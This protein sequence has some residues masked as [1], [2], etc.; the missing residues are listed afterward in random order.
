MWFNTLLAS[1]GRQRAHAGRQAPVA[2]PARGQGA[3]DHAAPR[4]VARRRPVAVGAAGGP[5]PPGHG[6]GHGGLRAQ[7]PVRLPVDEDRTSPKLFKNFK[8]APYPEVERRHSRP[9]HHRRHQPGREQLLASTPTWPSR[10]RCASAT[11]TTR[12]SAPSRAACRRRSPTSTTT[13]RSSADYPFRQDIQTS[14][15]DRRGA[16]ADARVPEH[17]DRHLAR[18]VAARGHRPAEHGAEDVEPDRRTPSTRRDWCRDR[19]ERPERH[20]RRHHRRGGTAAPRPSAKAKPTVRGRPGR[21][22]AR[23]DAVRAGRDH[24]ARRHRL[25]DRLRRSTCRCSATT[26]ASRRPGQV[27]RASPT[28][29]PCCRSPYW[30]HALV[31]H[32]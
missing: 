30:W 8:W 1:A 14:L 18:R 31:G 19:T 16:A 25:P 7:L 21:A 28:T 32:A 2:R 23:L 17:L 5:E 9:R 10:R 11:G 6:V 24:H 12:R 29:A 26:C 4:H 3:H 27:H 22:P 20:R 13:R 15:A